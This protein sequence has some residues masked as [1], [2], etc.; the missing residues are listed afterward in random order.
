MPKVFQLG[1]V[2]LGVTDFARTRDYYV[3]TLG[4]TEVDRDG[5]GTVYLSVGY[6][7][8]DMVLR[9]VDDK[10]LLHLG[11][12]LNPG[13]ELKAFA[14]EVQ[15]FGLPAELKSDS[16]PG[17]GEI[18]E[19]EG[20]GGN[21]F[22][23]YE[24]IEAPAPGYKPA[25]VAP[26][27]LGHVAVIS[28]EAGKLIAFY[29]DFL[30]FWETDWIGDLANFLTCNYEH[31]V[32]NI[33]EAP[34]SKVHH[35]AFQLHETGDHGRAADTLRARGVQ[36]KWGPSRHTAGHNLAAYH[37]DPDNTLIELY[38]DMDVWVPELNMCQP[39]PWHEHSPMRPKRWG[40]DEL[41]TWGVEFQ[42]DLAQG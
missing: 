19:V 20:P 36:T 2:A 10:A 31:H 29:R 16:Q 33:V 11:Y 38:T 6:A 34:P 37:Y 42:F 40:L 5:D 28:P 24:A 18:V 21:V 15:D 35:I 4:T 8:H 12:Q 9:P 30:G 17:I 27:R 14:R 41:S 13:T 32:V 25:T 26:L 23:F 7:H 39:R 22:Q 3:D 1:F